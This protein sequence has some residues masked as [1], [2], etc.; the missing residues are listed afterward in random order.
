VEEAQ[1]DRV[2]VTR[3]GRPAALIIGVAGESIEDLMTRSAPEF[4]KMI[5]ARRTAAKA[6]SAHEM[7]RRLGVSCKPRA[8]RKN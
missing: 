4:W 7:R 3:H 1:H 6:I 5:E 2:L 8:K